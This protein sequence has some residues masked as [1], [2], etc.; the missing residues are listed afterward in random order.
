MVASAKQITVTLTQE[1][2]DAVIKGDPDR[3]SRCLEPSV[4]RYEIHARERRVDVLMHKTETDVIVTVTD[5]GVVSRVIFYRMCLIDSG[6]QTARAPASTRAWDSASPSYVTSSSFMEARR[7]R[8]VPA[9][10][11]GRVLS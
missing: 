4:E 9:R 10:T 3:C 8:K 11:A 6:R 2:G 5:T 7:A 1:A